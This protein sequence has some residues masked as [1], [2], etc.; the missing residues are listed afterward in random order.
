MCLDG[1]RISRMFNTCNILFKLII[2]DSFSSDKYSFSVFVGTKV[3]EE[4]IQS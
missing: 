4:T 1:F 3:C 2:K